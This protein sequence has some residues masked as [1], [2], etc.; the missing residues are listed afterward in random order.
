M[1]PKQHARGEVLLNVEDI[2]APGY[3]MNR[4]RSHVGMV[5]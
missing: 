5:F 2:L 4:L 1:Y 3:S